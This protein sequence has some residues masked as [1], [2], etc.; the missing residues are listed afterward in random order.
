MLRNQRWG[1]ASL[2]MALTV[3]VGLALPAFGDDWRPFSGHADE[4]RIGAVPVDDGILVTTTGG[5]GDA[6]GLIHSAGQCGHSR[7]W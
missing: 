3:I 7:G 4:V 5:S 2:M 6:P 1:T